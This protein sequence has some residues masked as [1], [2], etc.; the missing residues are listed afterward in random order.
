MGLTMSLSLA[1]LE[2]TVN[3]FVSASLVAYLRH[4]F[5]IANIHAIQF[6]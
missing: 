2:Q 6:E 1:R 5:G 4:M 3:S